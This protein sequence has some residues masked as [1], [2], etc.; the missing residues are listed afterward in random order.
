MAR[1]RTVS[2]LLDIPN[3]GPAT[4]KDLHVLGIHT[5]AQLI[6]RDPYALYDVLCAKT[7]Q[8]HDPCV[9]DVLIS[10][11]RYMEGAPARPWWHYTAERKRTLAT[12]A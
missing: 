3:V 2:R 5:P 1:P 4:V 8:R 9:Y 6:G 10:A 11:V 7:A 12:R